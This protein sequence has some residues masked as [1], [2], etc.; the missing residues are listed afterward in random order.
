MA[1]YTK[2]YK[3]QNIPGA[4][5]SAHTGGGRTPPLDMVIGSSL[6]GQSVTQSVHQTVHRLNFLTAAS[7]FT[8]GAA[9]CL[10]QPPN[11]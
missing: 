3:A 9:K 1:V 7:A 2:K 6:S 4:E 10:A 5:Q 11:V 8:S